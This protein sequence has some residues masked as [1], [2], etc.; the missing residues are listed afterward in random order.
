VLQKLRTLY[1]F[2]WSTFSAVNHFLLYFLPWI[3]L[4]ILSYLILSYRSSRFR[5]SRKRP[6]NRSV[7]SENYG[8]L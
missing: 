6:N 1:K 4:S 2:L 3:T 8:Q 5:K 7:R